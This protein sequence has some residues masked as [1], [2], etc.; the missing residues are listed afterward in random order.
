MIVAHLRY[1]LQMVD[2]RPPFRPALRLTADAF[3]SEYVAV[4]KSRRPFVGTNAI[5]S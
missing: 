3:F 2:S 4:R 1:P 5:A